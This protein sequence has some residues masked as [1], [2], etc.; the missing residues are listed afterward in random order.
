MAPEFSRAIEHNVLS[1]SV[2]A[3]RLGVFDRSLMV[4]GL[5]AEDFVEARAGGEI[6][7][8]IARA[9]PVEGSPAAG[10]K[11]VDLCRSLA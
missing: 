2:V 3:Y 11:L 5:A 1:A 6:G 8:G 7:L 4:P 10:R 9:A